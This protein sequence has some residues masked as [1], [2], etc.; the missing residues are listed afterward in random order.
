MPFVEVCAVIGDLGGDRALGLLLGHGDTQ[1]FLQLLDQPGHRRLEGH[2]RP[3]TVE[4][5]CR[6]ESQVLLHKGRLS[7]D[8][9]RK[10][11]NF[12]PGR[13]ESRFRAGFAGVTWWWRR[14]A[15]TG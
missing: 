10:D 15:F 6:G 2:E 7:E 4:Q 14:P 5:D 1:T 9:G 13:L 12:P 11:R 8:P 3:E